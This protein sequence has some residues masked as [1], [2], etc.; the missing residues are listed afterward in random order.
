MPEAGQGHFNNREANVFGSTPGACKPCTDPA[1]YGALIVHEDTVANPDGRRHTI[2]VHVAADD[3]TFA[4][5]LPE[6][7]LPAAKD[8]RERVERPDKCEP[9]VPASPPPPSLAP[10]LKRE[11]LALR[12]EYAANGLNGLYPE[13]I[14]NRLS[15]TGVIRSQNRGKELVIYIHNDVKGEYYALRLHFHTEGHLIG[16]PTTQYDEIVSTP[17]QTRPSGAKSKAFLIPPHLLPD[18]PDEKPVYASII[19]ALRRPSWTLMFCDHQVF[20][21][22]HVIRLR[23]AIGYTELCPQSPWWQKLW[24]RNHGP[25]FWL[26]PEAT[27]DAL[28]NWR[29][30][31]I[32]K[33]ST[34]PILDVILESQHAVNGL[35]MQE[36]TDVLFYAFLH[37][38][39]P[40]GEVFASDVLWARLRQ[41]VIDNSIRV[42]NFVLRSKSAHFVPS[43]KSSTPSLAEGSSNIVEPEP[44]GAVVGPLPEDIVDADEHDDDA[45]VA[46][47]GDGVVRSARAGNAPPLDPETGLPPL[48]PRDLGRLPSVIS[49]SPFYYNI[50]A[51]RKYIP[52]ILCYKREFF[53]PNQAWLDRGWELGVLDPHLLMRADGVPTAPAPNEMPSRSAT[54]YKPIPLR[55]RNPTNKDCRIR[56]PIYAQKGKA[57][58]SATASR[59]YYSP[60]VVGAPAHWPTVELFRPTL[61]VREVILDSTLGPYSYNLF[62]QCAA[63]YREGY[64]PPPKKRGRPPKGTTRA[65]NKGVRNP[66][67][68]FL[69]SLSFHATQSRAVLWT[70]PTSFPPRKAD[71]PPPPPT[72]PQPKAKRKLKDLKESWAD[73]PKPRRPRRKDTYTPL[74]P[75]V[76][77]GGKIGIKPSAPGWQKRVA[78]EAA[79]AEEW[80]RK[81]RRL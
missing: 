68:D 28:D 64:K 40:A 26:E 50:A 66:V 24:G 52:S 51:H 78:L 48:V 58:I 81:R 19:A 74:K 23:N 71:T 39:Q 59:L 46:D 49:K 41:S 30:E 62:C 73:K 36:G 3:D 25:V 63:A 35:G 20:F 79:E 32:R 53:H 65:G 67:L 6:A 33:R 27:C 42:K 8:S 56:I 4:L 69:L 13:V 29:A 22:M 43:T 14:V 31:G 45:S 1:E 77:G 47:D 57:S 17:A 37:P 61:D 38:L 70:R 72:P 55:V 75:V 7:I 16:L 76:M 11:A 9:C 34:R 80:A 44:V 54:V 21:R 12:K 15:I 60:F 2:E 10:A 5:P 18:A